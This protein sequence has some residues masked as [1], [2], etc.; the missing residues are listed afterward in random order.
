MGLGF[1]GLGWRVLGRDSMGL[2][3]FQHMQNSYC[4]GLSK[5]P[6]YGLLDEGYRG[7]MGLRCSV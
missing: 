4:R 6:Y 1:R 5:Y 7:H 3:G 2:P